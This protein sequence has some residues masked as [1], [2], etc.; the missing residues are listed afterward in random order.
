[1]SNTPSTKFRKRRSLVLS[2]LALPLSLSGCG[3]APVVKAIFSS[4]VVAWQDNQDGRVRV[5]GFNPSGTSDMFATVQVHTS[6]SGAQR[7]PAVAASRDRFVVVWVDTGDQSVR[8]R[9]FNLNGSPRGGA[10]PIETSVPWETMPGGSFGSVTNWHAPKVA[11]AVDGAFVVCWSRGRDHAP[12]A[13]SFLPDGTALPTVDVAPPSGVG[14]DVAI[15]DD[16][17]FVVTWANEDSSRSF[18]RGF[19][20]NGVIRF[21]STPI[22]ISQ[23]LGTLEQAVAVSPDGSRIVVA[24]G[25]FQDPDNPAPVLALGFDGNGNSRF[26]RQAPSS[27]TV[28]NGMKYHPS[29]ATGADGRFFVTWTDDRDGNNVGNIRARLFASDGSPIGDDLRVN[30]SAAGSQTFPCVSN[31]RGG[32]YAFVWQ[33]AQGSNDD[34]HG[35]GL[36]GLDAKDE[37]VAQRVINDATAG[38][39]VIPRVAMIPPSP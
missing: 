12:K 21:G 3:L 27:F 9:L 26:N 13:R 22:Q 39:Q 29:I 15:S 23:S 4:F 18:L 34:I 24:Q 38:A 30:T 35:R 25:C 14:V 36:L 10:F 20:P 19:T 8:A 5:R 16:R 2:S 33:D 11:M 28:R 17:N 31:N 1:M 37:S 7:L 32:A 6:P